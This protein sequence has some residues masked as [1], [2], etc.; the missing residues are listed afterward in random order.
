VQRTAP[1]PA[2]RSHVGWRELALLVSIGLFWGLNWPAVRVILTE[3][4]PFTMR[5]TAFALGA[6]VLLLVARAR[7]EHLRPGRAEWAP[8]LVVSLLSIFGF[9][10]LTA[11]G[12][13]HTETGRAAI[14]AFTMPVWATVLSMAFL[15]DRLTWE[16]ALALLLGMAGLALLLGEDVLSPARSPLGSLFALGAALSWAAG[17]VLLKQRTWSLPALPLAAWMLAISAVPAALSA[18]LLEQPWALAT[19]SWG[20][21]VVFA[22]HVL[23]PMVWCYA[24]WVVLVARLPAPVA[25]IG[26]LM[27]PVVG[28]VSA[29]LL[30]GEPAL[31]HKFLALGLVVTGVALVLVVPGLKARN[32]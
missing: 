6:V 30:L 1:A 23:F 15:G 21:V 8:L 17:T 27:I 28:V 7:S 4:P 11:F 9:N 20:V 14:I 13:L 31:L 22:Y 32:G 12:Q 2:T 29:V 26:T 5:G 3:V 18:L 24:A 16:R 19:P 25:A 10:I